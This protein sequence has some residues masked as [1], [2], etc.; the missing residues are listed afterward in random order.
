MGCPKGEKGIQKWNSML[1]K[2]MKEK[3]LTFEYVCTQKIRM[4]IHIQKQIDVFKQIHVKIITGQ[5]VSFVQRDEYNQCM[6]SR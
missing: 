6:P 5:F 2:S 3:T 4:E 1:K